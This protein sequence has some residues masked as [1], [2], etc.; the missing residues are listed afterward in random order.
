MDSLFFKRVS[1]ATSLKKT[2]VWTCCCPYIHFHVRDLW[3]ST[4][5]HTNEPTSDLETSFVTILTFF[6]WINISEILTSENLSLLITHFDSY[7]LPYSCMWPM[8]CVYVTRDTRV[9]EWWCSDECHTMHLLMPLGDPQMNRIIA[10]AGLI[11]TVMYVTC[12]A[13]LNATLMHLPM[14]QKLHLYIFFY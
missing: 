1:V 14:T 4:E 10:V 6:W 8:M 12:D 2:E 11:Y 13:V 9:R 7:V 5:C 3:H